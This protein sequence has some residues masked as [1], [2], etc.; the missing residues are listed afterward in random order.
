MI[1]KV[2]TMTAGVAA[3]TNF[4][5]A[6]DFTTQLESPTVSRTFADYLTGGLKLY[7][8]SSNPYIQEVGFFGRAQYQY[9][10][11]DGSS[12]DGNFTD[13]GGELRRLRVGTKVKFLNKFELKGNIDLESGGFRNTSLRAGSLDTATLTYKAGD[14]GS[15]EDVSLA[16]GRHKHTFGGEAH[17]SSKKIKTIERANVTN[18]FF[19]S[20]RP[21]G[22]V[23]EA[24]RNGYEYK[25]GIYSANDSGQDITGDYNDIAYYFNIQKDGWNLDLFY[26][27]NNGSDDEF[28]N[29]KWGTSLAYETEYGDWNLFLNALYGQSS[30][31]ENDDVWGLIVTPSKFL[32][33]DKLEVVF[34]YQY[35]GSSGDQIDINSRNVANVANVDGVSVNDGDENHTF[36]A[37][38]NYYFVG[39]NSKVLLGVEYESLEG[40]NENLEATTFWAA[41]RIFF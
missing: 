25:L 24:A 40:S 39:N 11:T 33:E 15:F 5:T 26:N 23:F 18:F 1:T 6:G 38:L 7:K 36:Y 28:S 19:D 16:F 10:L 22:L 41:Y 8:S 14:I 12:E 27:D 9:G 13:A 29:V 34:R 20:S 4:A 35:A 17:Q 3:L 31:P 30:D 37:G 2:L 32:I 21:T